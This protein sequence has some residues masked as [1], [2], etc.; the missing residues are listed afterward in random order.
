MES[1]YHVEFCLFPRQSKFHVFR[2]IEGGVG[3]LAHFERL[4]MRHMSSGE[5]VKHELKWDP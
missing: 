3:H 5:L 1:S 2:G 4:K